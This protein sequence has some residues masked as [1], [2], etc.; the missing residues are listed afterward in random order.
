MLSLQVPFQFNSQLTR[1]SSLTFQLQKKE[2]L[3]WMAEYSNRRRKDYYVIRSK[4]TF[5]CFSENSVQDQ[6]VRELVRKYIRCSSRLTIAQIKKFLKVK[7]NLKTADQV[8]ACSIL[9]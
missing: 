5:F 7:L 9:D 2:L 3:Y 8:S 1:T 6:P 4:F